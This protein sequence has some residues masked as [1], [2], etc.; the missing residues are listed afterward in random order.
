[1]YDTN[2]SALCHPPRVSFENRDRMDSPFGSVW[3]PLNHVPSRSKSVSVQL[4]DVISD[5]VSVHELHTPS[6]SYSPPIAF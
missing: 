6:V 3:I 2:K 5:E 4:V 1:M